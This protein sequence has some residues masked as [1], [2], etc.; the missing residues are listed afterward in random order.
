MQMHFDELKTLY[1]SLYVNV[2]DLVVCAGESS[3]EEWARS[4]VAYNRLELISKIAAVICRYRPVPI[5]KK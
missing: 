4:E 3:A 1:Q 2:D 5:S